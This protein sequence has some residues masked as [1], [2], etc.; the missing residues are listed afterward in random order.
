MKLLS[1][2]EAKS[3][4]TKENN[5]LIAENIRLRKEYVSLLKRLANLEKDGKIKELKEFEEFVKVTQEKKSFLLSELH[6]V[7][8]EI[9]SRQEI[10]DG[11]IERQDELQE[12]EYKLNDRES[13]LNLRE[14]FIK[15]IEAKQYELV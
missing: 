8:K 15:E 5:F 11:I 3:E 12:K 6:R 13:K 9:R 7:D 2:N 1:K 14:N 10:L 4:I